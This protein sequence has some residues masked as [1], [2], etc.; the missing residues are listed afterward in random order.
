[1]QNQLFFLFLILLI[2]N[3]LVATYVVPSLKQN[4][5]TSM[6][7][8]LMPSIVRTTYP[9]IMSNGNSTI[10]N[11]TK[12]NLVS[13]P[14]TPSKLSTKKPTIFPPILLTFEPS[15]IPS[16]KPKNFKTK[17]LI[18]QNLSHWSNISLLIIVICVPR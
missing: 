10:K 7:R 14:V 1:M 3:A 11:K 4:L 12:L 13:N 9:T 8:S 18:I 15:W 16:Y 6:V 17:I 5:K 2:R